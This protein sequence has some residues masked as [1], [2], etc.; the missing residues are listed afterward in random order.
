MKRKTYKGE[1]KEKLKENRKTQ[2]MGAEPKNF[3]FIFLQTEI[4]VSPALPAHEVI[5]RQTLDRP[6]QSSLRLQP[7]PSAC[8]PMNSKMHRKRLVYLIS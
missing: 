2:P 5:F 4:S 3:T 8:Y 6:L 1:T 7:A